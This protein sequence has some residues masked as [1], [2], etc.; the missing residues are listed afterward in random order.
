MP[1]RP[2]DPTLD[3]SILVPFTPEE[4]RRLLDYAHAMERDAAGE[5]RW[6]LRHI[7][8]GKETAAAGQAA[9]DVPS[10]ATATR[11]ERKEHRG[12]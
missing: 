1:R 2:Y 9:E 5:I 10:S 8:S 3:G 4:K 12:A 11:Q 6:R 7:L